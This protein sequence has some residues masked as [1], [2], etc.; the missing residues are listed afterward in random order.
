MFD[1]VLTWS[2]FVWFLLVELKNQNNLDC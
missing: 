1:L 2:R